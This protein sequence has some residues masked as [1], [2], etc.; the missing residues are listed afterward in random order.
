MMTIRMSIYL[1]RDADPILVQVNHSRF[2]T[3]TPASRATEIRG[4]AA[5]VRCSIAIIIAFEPGA[6]LLSFC[7][8]SRASAECVAPRA[9][10]GPFERS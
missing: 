7:A 6:I 1:D 2:M 8:S 4:T 5:S 9:D 3:W 10:T